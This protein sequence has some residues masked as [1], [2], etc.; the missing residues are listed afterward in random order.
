MSGKQLPLPLAPVRPVSPSQI[1]TFQECQRKWAWRN[2]AKVVLP[3]HKSASLGTEVHAQLETYLGG[4]SFDFTRATGDIAASAIGLLPPPLSKGVEIEKKFTFTSAA[5]YIYHGF[6]DLN[7][8]DSSVFPG[9]QNTGLFLTPFVS[10]HKSTSNLAYAKTPEDL[11]TD[12]QG[13]IYAK[14]VFEKYPAA[15]QADLIWTYILTR[16]AKKAKRTHLRVL[17]ADVEKEFAKLEITVSDLVTTHQAQTDPLSLPPNTAACGN[18]GG[19]PYRA[20]CTDLSAINPQGKTMTPETLDML[21]GLTQKLP[22]EERPPSDNVLPDWMNSAPAAVPDVSPSADLLQDL[23]GTKEPAVN[24]YD[25]TPPAE[26]VIP[27]SHHPVAINP[28]GEAQDVSASLIPKPEK[29]AKKGR[30]RPKKN[31]ASIGDALQELVEETEALGLY[32][33]E[34]AT[35]PAPAEK[36]WTLY[37]DCFPVGGRTTQ[38]ESLFTRVHARVLKDSGVED[39]RMIDYGKGAGIFVAAMDELMEEHDGSDIFL[40]TR[41][42]EGSLCLSRLSTKATRV[43]RGLR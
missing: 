28:P 13:V 1:A 35:V 7:G 12:P 9:I 32:D 11:K 19:C 40:D 22:V 2:I 41:T 30:G 15:Q 18:Y 6:M 27:G 37:V 20:Y 16:G 5:G 25:H 23:L 33:K 39:Y 29:A 36:T 3:P 43:I 14:A 38:A 10:D 34:I 26:T 42:P 4:G 21:N 24:Y 17:K 31:A 8:P